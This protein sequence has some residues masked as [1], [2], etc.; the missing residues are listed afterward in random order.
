MCLCLCTLELHDII[1]C[2]SFFTCLNFHSQDKFLW[3]LKC[4]HFM[5]VLLTV[6]FLWRDTMAKNT[7]KR[8]HF[9]RVCLIISECYSMIIMEKSLAAGRQHDTVAAS[10]RLHLIHKLEVERKARPGIS[11]LNHKV[12]SQ[13]HI[14]FNNAIY[15]NP[16]EVNI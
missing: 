6:L 3:I 8:K 9:I 7:Y 1:P 10:E 14:L 11:L 5:N 15:P 4:M 16:S 12:H 2:S 13:W